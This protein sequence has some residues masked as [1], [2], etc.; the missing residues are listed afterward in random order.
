M[1]QQI[2]YIMKHWGYDHCKIEN[3][4]HQE[5]SRLIYLISR[6]QEQR[7]ILKG[8]PDSISETVIKGN[9]LAHEYLGNGKGI[10]P[11]IYYLLDGKSYLH[12]DDYHFYLIEYIEGRMLEET[13]EDEDALGKLARELHSYKDYTYPT[14]LTCNKAKF[15][16]WFHEKSFKKEF[17]AILDGIPD[18]DI[19]EQCFIHTDLGPHNAMMR[20]N[21][22]VVLVDLDDAGLGSKYLGLG[23]P[24]IMQ[25]VKFD[26]QSHDKEY[27]FDLANAFLQGYYGA[28]T[29]SR[30]EYELLWQGAIYMHISYMQTFG[31]DAIDSLWE[32]LRYGMEQQEELWRILSTA[33]IETWQ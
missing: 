8:L 15:Y 11:K 14:G 4:F 13:V 5:S 3:R 16:T 2:N 29:L 20:N 30:K 17:D 19:Y 27:R 25:F 26:K 22:S 18:F 28:D 32:I 23:W 7:F 9:V 24:L 31:P 6:S 21:G 1:E 33:V 10:A 12:I